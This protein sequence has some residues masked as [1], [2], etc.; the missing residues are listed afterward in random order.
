MLY[1]VFQLMQ[2]EMCIPLGEIVGLTHLGENNLSSSA[3]TGLGVCVSTAGRAVCSLQQLTSR[4]TA[5]PYYELNVC[6]NLM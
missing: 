3:A 4:S 5:L 6:F 2:D 1:V